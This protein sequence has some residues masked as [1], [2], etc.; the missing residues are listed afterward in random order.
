[1]GF[2]NYLIFGLVF[3]LVIGMYV[4]STVD[5]N[6]TISFTG[7]PIDLPKS[8]WILI[9]SIVLYMLTILHLMFYGVINFFQFRKIRSDAN[10]FVKNAKRVLLGKLINDNHYKSEV[11]RL[12]G[13]ILPVLNIDH[14]EASNHRIDDNDIQEISN[15]KQKIFSGG[16]VDLSKYGL[17][18]DNKLII[19]ND[20]NLLDSDPSY[21]SNILRRSSDKG[22]IEK[23][24]QIIAQ[25]FPI[26]E[27]RKYDITINKEIFQIILERMKSDAQFYIN[28]EDVI[29]LVNRLN[30]DENDF[31]QLSKT[32][33]GRF[34]P[35]QR[36][37]FVQ[38]LLDK[39]PLLA[40]EAYLYT[41]FDLQMIDEAREYLDNSAK[42][43]NIKFK[44]LL[45]LKDNGKSFDIELFV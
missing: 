23:A 31:L 9:P 21:A 28:Y 19:K 14:R 15:D 16:S 24:T 20:S 2:K 5:G 8:I 44:H 11:F 37:E 22:L 3:L 27:L 29:E 34:S 42:D 33:K 10:K 41:M 12:P 45:F 7:I 18:D 13:Q 4:N 39:F 36:V 1:M 17:R 35:D 32:I 38:T 43:E 30:L 25:H 40:G 26:S 6:H